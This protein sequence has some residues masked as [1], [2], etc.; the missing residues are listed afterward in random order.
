[1]EI[2]AAPF[3]RTIRSLF[4]YET[5]PTCA[6]RGSLDVARQQE[7]LGK[8]ALRAVIGVEEFE[9]ALPYLSTKSSDQLFTLFWIGKTYRWEEPDGCALVGTGVS[10]MQ[11]PRYLGDTAGDLELE[12]HHIAAS[13]PGLSYRA[14]RAAVER[15]IDKNMLA[16]LSVYYAELDRGF[17]N[18]H[19]PAVGRVLQSVGFSS[20]AKASVSIV[21]NEATVGKCV[22]TFKRG[23]K[24]KIGP[25]YLIASSRGLGIG[26]RVVADLTAAADS[27]G[28][29]GVYATVPAP[30]ESAGRAFRAAGYEPEV[31]LRSHYMA[32]VDE[33]VFV[34][35]L[36][37]ALE[38][39]RPPDPSLLLNLAY[40]ER[41]IAGEVARHYFPIDRR[42]IEWLADRSGERES[43]RSKPH[44]L[45]RDRAGD[46][47]LVI[48]KRGGTMKV[49]PSSREFSSG[50]TASWERQAKIRH[51]RKISVFVTTA[52]E[53]ETY[54]KEGEI[55]AGRYSCW[56]RVA[57]WSKFV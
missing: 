55:E 10:R 53:V 49:V 28:F 7:V 56:K 12:M 27:L 23:R 29:K 6:F 46:S 25:I 13:V 20:L 30:N 44:E 5:A 39:F 37:N 4:L 43:F 47:A 35:R 14:P 51:Q 50:L 22:L 21:V 24:M 40:D 15:K 42:W 1:M 45:V 34:R 11:S 31:T 17:R 57:I 18:T 8:H 16:D 3:R 26:S 48:Y 52:R 33:V 38:P 54:G 32:G 36:S 2:R 9:R 19:V 41:R